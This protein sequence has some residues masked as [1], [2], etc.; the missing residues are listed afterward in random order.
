V[1]LIAACLAAVVLSCTPE[2]ERDIRETVT[3]P[4]GQHIATVILE[5]CHATSPSVTVVSIRRAADKLD[6]DDYVFSGAKGSVATTIAWTSPATLV[7][8]SADAQVFRRAERWGGVAVR[9]ER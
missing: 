2:C 1:R 4:D 3:S 5:N 8:R 9:Y 7:I 6:P